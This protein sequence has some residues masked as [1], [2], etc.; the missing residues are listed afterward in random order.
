M[1]NTTIKNTLAGIWCHICFTDD[2]DEKLY[3]YISFQEEYSDDLQISDDNT[4]YYLST[5]ELEDLLTSIDNKETM[6][7]VDNDWYIVL[8]DGYV[9]EYLKEVK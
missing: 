9:P 8:P 6:Y 7:Q 1:N 5:D 3:R 2:P 4:F